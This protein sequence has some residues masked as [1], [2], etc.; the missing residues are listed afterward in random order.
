MTWLPHLLTFTPT[1]AFGVG[2][3]ED[4]DAEDDV[5]GV[6]SMTSYDLTLAAEGDL[7]S[8]RKYGWTGSHDTGTVDLPVHV[9]KPYIGASMLT[10][11]LLVCRYLGTVFFC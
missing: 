6:E 1:Q 8:E 9:F 11:Q 2:A 10:D 7:S 5:Y 3:L 4:D